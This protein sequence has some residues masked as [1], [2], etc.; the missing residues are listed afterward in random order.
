[1]SETKI[2]IPPLSMHAITARLF[3]HV[4]KSVVEQFGTEG[5][6][7][8]QQGVKNFGYQDAEDIATDATTKNEN[9]I[10]FDYIPVD[11]QAENK[12]NNL[13]IYALM[14]KLFAAIAKAVVDSYGS[15]GEDAIREGVR[16]FGEERGRGIAQR[17]RANGKKNTIDNYL[18][19]YDMERSDLFTYTTEYKPEEIEQNFTVCPFGQQWADDQMHEYGILYCQM[20]DPAVA[21]GFN[22]NFEVEH[23]QYILR[24]GNCH[25][26][27]K[28]KEDQHD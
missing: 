22:P 17:A 8:I 28:L 5:K 4:E 7:L 11:H 25:F 2:N 10:L 16:T 26:R 23:D 18:T 27:F 21:N 24:E 19:N 1:M 13:T 9:H 6:T 15:E 3:T 20:I 14:A 12:Y